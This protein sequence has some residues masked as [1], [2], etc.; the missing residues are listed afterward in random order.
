MYTKVDGQT[1]T[2]SII[3]MRALA[4]AGDPILP[5]TTPPPATKKKALK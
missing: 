1:M 5:A 2:D 3:P 4:S